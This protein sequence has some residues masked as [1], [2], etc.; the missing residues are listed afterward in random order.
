M[1]YGPLFT[2]LGT[3]LDRYC[4]DYH[5]GYVSTLD[6]FNKHYRE[7][8]KL[9]ELNGK[10]KVPYTMHTNKNITK[11]LYEMELFDKRDGRF[12]TPAVTF[13]NGV[14]TSY[15]LFKMKKRN[16]LFLKWLP[17]VNW[18]LSK[19]IFSRMISGRYY[20][21][22]GVPFEAG[23][24]LMIF[25]VIVAILFGI[26]LVGWF[27]F[28][29]HMIP[30]TLFGLLRFRYPLKFL[31]NKAVVW[32]FVILDIIFTYLWLLLMMSYGLTWWIVI[33]VIFITT[34]FAISKFIQYMND[35]P[36]NRC[37]D[38]KYMHTIPYTW[39]R[40]DLVEEKWEWR[41]EEKNA[42]AVGKYQRKGQTF[43]Q[44]TAPTTKGGRVQNVEKLIKE[45][46][47]HSE[48]LKIYG[49]NK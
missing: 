16:T 35:F 13:D 47:I 44:V 18:V 26:A 41:E 19:P 12:Y 17:G 1:K 31:S 37:P 4:I 32:S 15:E 28:T 23:I 38:C 22:G 33:P 34:K 11:V 5:T 43:T 42:G 24:V 8:M 9:S 2:V 21:A 10:N 49:Y 46:K 45:L 40:K 39:V 3:D 27:F 36:S 29:N 25:G 48:P 7:G 6:W 30:L 20:T 14:M